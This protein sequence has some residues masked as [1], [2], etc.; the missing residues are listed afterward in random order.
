MEKN[1]RN[2]HLYSGFCQI[3][4]HGQLFAHEYIGVVR[5]REQFLERGQLLWGKGR[6]IPPL[7]KVNSP[8]VKS[9]FKLSQ[10]SFQLENKNK[11]K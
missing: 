2:A 7:Q 8:G 4:A 3:N 1:N 10:N 11:I 6:T 5:P 9:N